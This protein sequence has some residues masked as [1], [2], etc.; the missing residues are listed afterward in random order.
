MLR[1]LHLTEEESEAVEIA[2]LKLQYAANVGQALEKIRNAE[3]AAASEFLVQAHAHTPKWRF[4][5]ARVG[6]AIAPR[7]VRFALR[8]LRG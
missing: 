8:Q 6:L 1:R 4:R 5:A 3:F 2:Y 7:I